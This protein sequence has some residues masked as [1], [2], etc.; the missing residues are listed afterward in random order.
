MTGSV[1]LMGRRLQ[2]HAMKKRKTVFI[3]LAIAIVMSILVYSANQY[4]PGFLHRL[5]KE[6]VASLQKDGILLEYDS[7][8][9]EL[10]RN[11]VAIDTLS[12][13]L[14][15]K[16]ISAKVYGCHIN[17]IRLLP[18]LFRKR[19]H[20]EDLTID[21]VAVSIIK[22]HSKDSAH[23]TQKQHDAFAMVN[24]CTI[25]HL[26]VR[27][28]NALSHD[29]VTMQGSISL[30]GFT[31]NGEK[32]PWDFSAM[33][34]DSLVVHSPFYVVSVDY[35]DIDRERKYMHL[36]TLRIKPRFSK[37]E[38]ARRKRVEDDRFHGIITGV[39]AE[40]LRFNVGDSAFVNTSLLKC[41]FALDV[42]RNKHY[43]F[44]K[45]TYMPLPMD[46]LRKLPFALAVDTLR[47]YDSAVSY[48]E[49]GEE[50]DSSGTIYFK[51]LKAGIFH[52]STDTSLPAPYMEA[53]AL[54]M[55]SGKLLVTCQF[56]NTSKPAVLKGSLSDMPLQKMNDMLKPQVKIQ[57]ESGVMT[58]L[59]F[60]FRFNDHRSDGTVDISYR[61]LKLTSLKS[62]KDQKDKAVKNNL[63]TL[64]I[65]T[66]V[67]NDA[68]RYVTGDKQTG[69]ILFYRDRKKAIFNYWWKSILS[70]L[71][72]S[73]SL[74][75][76]AN[77][78]NVKKLAQKDVEKRKHK[79]E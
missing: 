4:L 65:N 55:G 10:W 40:G 77:K 20:L 2:L 48:E 44:P 49:I 25:N 29:T 76:K 36:D 69:I 16:R 5:V 9:L 24:V 71:K 3:V 33:R 37:S 7:I 1:R 35:F 57:V 43:P 66:F 53:S 52:I 30:T 58:R 73:F 67:K 34:A 21:S 14:I 78:D 62:D 28:E 17:T 13:S 56:S 47:I 72:S 51:K 38:H 26:Y 68:G 79:K 54:F 27:S 6:K 45:R 19:I 70:G 12:F 64:A 22:L 11:R 75:V 18:L 60:S 74:R 31:I 46:A 59:N 63:L 42:F 32:D 23:R 41:S 50:A 61:D 15:D 8:K 39:T